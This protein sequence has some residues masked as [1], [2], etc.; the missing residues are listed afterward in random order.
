VEELDAAAKSHQATELA[1]GAGAVLDALLR[2]RRSA[3]SIA[4]K[5]GSAASRRGVSTRAAERRRTA[6]E[7]VQQKTDELADLEQE[8]LDEVAEID[9]K[10]QDKA[11]DV[12]TVPIRLE[13]TDVR[14]A[15][16]ALVWIPAP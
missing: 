11:A 10:W 5:I 3:R 15:E 2:G 6:A 12:E 13:S 7:R 16:L 14:V 4:S 8:L 9:A 1:A